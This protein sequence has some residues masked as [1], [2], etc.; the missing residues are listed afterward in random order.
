MKWRSLEESTQTTETRTLQEVYAERKEL[1]SKYVPADIQAVHARVVNELKQ[2]GFAEH[3]LKAGHAAPEFEL[4]D[5]NGKPVRSSG[6]LERGPLVICFLRGRWCPFCVGQM[7]A[8]NEIVSHLQQLGAS[9]VGVSPQTV[10]Q[11]YLMAD[12]HKLRFRLLSDTGNQVARQFGL[13]YRVPEYQQEVYARA[14]T[15]LPFINGDSSWELPIPATYVIG[16]AENENHRDHRGSQ[17]EQSQSEPDRNTILYASVNSDY[18]DRP[19]PIE[20]LKA[21]PQRLS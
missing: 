18:T 7:E 16:A 5:H 4:P 19:E 2:S 11:S 17:S 9:L 3:A 21:I 12:Q 1:I 6:L 13:V 8:M 15:N 14:F 20:V 10:H